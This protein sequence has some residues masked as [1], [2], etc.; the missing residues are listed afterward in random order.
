VTRCRRALQRGFTLT[1]LAVVLLIV[2]LV[3]GGTLMTLSA[4][5]E[6]RQIADTQRT[7]EQA[8]EAIIGFAIRAERLP[9]PASGATGVETFV[10]ATDLSCAVPATPAN[11]FVPALTLGI[12]PTDAQG[13]LIDA[14]GNRIRYY[15]SQWSQNPPL[16]ANCPPIP[17]NA[18]PLDFTRCPAFTT[19]GA[20]KN[21]GL[22]TLPSAFPQLLRVCD[23]AA[24]TG[25]V[26][27]TPAVIL[28]PGRNFAREFGAGAA[29][30][31]D[32]ETNV[33]L[34]SAFDTTFVAHD[35]RAGGALGGEFD[36]LLLWLSPN[37]LY[38]RLIAAGAI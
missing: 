25:Q 5:N 26:F 2:G 22:T 33:H 20:M 13:F 38:H 36:D 4:Q 16:P 15:V 11:Q 29:G 10:S 1:E 18:G 23:A 28:S 34:G 12:G 8:R 24:C 32:E 3:I 6:V 9:C 21:L 17:P 14:W 37:I 7:L 27:A 35:A 31:V 30:G 19:A